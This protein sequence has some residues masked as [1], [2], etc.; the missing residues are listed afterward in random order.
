MAT[1]A[2]QIK[3]IVNDLWCWRKRETVDR[4]H[5][6][7]TFLQVIPFLDLPAYFPRQAKPAGQTVQM[8]WT[9]WAPERMEH[10]ASTSATVRNPGYASNQK[11]LTGVASPASHHPSPGFQVIWGI[12]R[13]KLHNYFDSQGKKFS[14]HPTSILPA[15]TSF[16]WRNQS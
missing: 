16:L 11:H 10:S 12:K 15:Q 14:K 8:M 1:K 9:R 4:S 5:F 3:D 2:K 13:R 7:L 6:P